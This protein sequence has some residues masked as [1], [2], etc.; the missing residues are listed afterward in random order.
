MKI[1]F[2]LFLIFLLTGSLAAQN[3]EF[4]ASVLDKKGKPVK[5][6][7]F[8]TF[9]V[10]QKASTDK[11]GMCV[12]RDIT[13]KDSLLV[14]FSGSS[15]LAGVYSLSGLSELQFNTEKTELVAYNP[16]TS[17]WITGK[18]K[19][20]IRK[21]EFDVETEISN[22]A[23]NLEDL[24]KRMPSLMVTGGN[25]SLR[26]PVQTNAFTNTSPLIVVDGMAVRGGLS[27]AN[28]TVNIHQI[29]SIEIERDGTLWGKE[30][31]NGAILI[32]LKK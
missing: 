19:R 8:E 25:I 14:L 23:T 31:V 27:E 6:A 10:K 7:R 1:I 22:G 18:S 20:I 12:L 2:Q 15:S 21:G 9:P 28:R 13:D 3:R 5:G 4:K 29:E 32:K 24:L 30:A 16:V 26:T 11:T 17:S